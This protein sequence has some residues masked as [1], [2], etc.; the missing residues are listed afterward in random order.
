MSD[1][2]DRDEQIVLRASAARWVWVLIGS[3]AFAMFG[4]AMSLGERTGAVA[5]GIGVVLLVLFGFCTIVALRE[6]R[7]PGSLTIT[8]H[9]MNIVSRGRLTTFALADCGRFSIWRNPSRGSTHVVF[10]YSADPDTDLNR[11][12]RRLMGGSRSLHESYGVSAESLVDL[13]N[14]ARSAGRSADR[15]ARDEPDGRD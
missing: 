15:Q 9:E 2:A 8:R 4:G 6:M 1:D 10:D 7:A 14:Q 12:N 5:K 11:A 3:L 13:L